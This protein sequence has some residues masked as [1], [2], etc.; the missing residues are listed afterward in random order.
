MWTLDIGCV[1]VVFMLYERWILIG[2][3]KPSVLK[4]VVCPDNSLTYHL[5]KY[6]F[7]FL[8]VLHKKSQSSKMVTCL[9][10]A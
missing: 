5:L 10:S 3:T 9:F 6:L 7:W 4:Y 8:L 1:D 2:C